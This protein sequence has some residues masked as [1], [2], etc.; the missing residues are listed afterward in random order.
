MKKVLYNVPQGSVLGPLLFIMY[1][2]CL[3]DI[4]SILGGNVVLYV[5]DTNVLIKGATREI[6]F[7]AAFIV[8]TKSLEIYSALNLST[9]KKHPLCSSLMMLQGYLIYNLILTL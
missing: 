1:T 9:G 6:V 3:K 5:D 2:N 8:L 4:I 7:R